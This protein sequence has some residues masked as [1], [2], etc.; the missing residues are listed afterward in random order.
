MPLFAKTISLY[1]ALPPDALLDRIRGLTT[2][3]LPM[4]PQSRWRSPVRWWLREQPD[5]IRLMPLFPPSYIAQQPSFIGTIEPE[6]SGSGVKGRVAPFGLTVGITAFLLFAIAAMTIAGVMQQLSRHGPSKAMPMALIGIGLVAVAVS[7]LRLSVWFA[8]API[9][10]L[11]ETAAS[12]DPHHAI[13][14]GT[15]QP[16]D[17]IVPETIGRS[18]KGSFVLRSA[19]AIDLL[20]ALFL[21]TTSFVSSRVGRPVTLLIAAI[22]ASGAGVLFVITNRLG[23]DRRE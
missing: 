15:I 5:A 1:S 13:E 3:K 19:A 20:I 7:M 23:S 22:L 21:I 18:T 16:T 12:S 6:G 14:E 11:L 8:A 4:P 9:R 17:A 10:Q 2:G